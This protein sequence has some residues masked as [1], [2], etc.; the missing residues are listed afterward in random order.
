MTFRHKKQRSHRRGLAWAAGALLFLI[1]L[2]CVYCLFVFAPTPG[3]QK[4]RSSYIQTAMSTL[5]HQWLAT[6]FIPRDI[7]DQV[8]EQVRQDQQAQQGATSTWQDPTAGSS[9]GAGQEGFF[10]LFPQLDRAAVLAYAEKNPQ[11][12]SEGWE[13]F[14]A[15]ESGL[16][17]QGLPLY[18]TAGDQVLAID[19]QY[20]ILVL[21]VRQ[22]LGTGVLAI[23]ADPAGLCLAKAPNGLG[24]IGD[25]ADS[26]GGV[27][28]ITASGFVESTD[29]VA[30]YAMYSGQTEGDFHA[31]WHKRLELRSDNRLYITDVWDDF[32]PDCTD[33]M[34]FSPALI[35]D[36]KSMLED[37]SDFSS[38]HPRVCLGQD[39]DGR[40]LMLAIQGRILESIGATAADC[41]RILSRYNCRQ[42]MNLDGGNSAMLV[43]RGQYLLEGSSKTYPIGRETVNAWVYAPVR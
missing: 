5:N 20:G 24:Y 31:P 43:Y 9:Q 42:A 33:A 21:R 3:L 15:N 26:V 16:E 11:V 14:Y 39:E 2:E 10:S 27:V 36:G 28:A 30:G 17:Q 4:L 40:I 1:L 18:T 22:G 34:E 19:A 35:I 7:V 8:M 6:A 13:N 41:V 32:H 38:I 23:C 25:I 29:T 12:I 37:D